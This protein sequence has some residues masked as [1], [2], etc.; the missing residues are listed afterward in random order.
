MERDLIKLASIGVSVFLFLIGITAFFGIYNNFFEVESD[1][2][3]IEI[4]DNDITNETYYTKSDIYFA[5][6]NAKEENSQNEVNGVY[7]EVAE[8]YVNGSK[9]DSALEDE[10]IINEL[11][12]FGSSSFLKQLENDDDKITSIRFVSR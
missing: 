5:Y 2:Y 8:V 4:A 11:A 7:G 12:S 10:E 6:V 1:I 9:L 3:D